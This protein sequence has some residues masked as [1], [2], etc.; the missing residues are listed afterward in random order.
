MNT[1]VILSYQ[2]D[3]ILAAIADDVLFRLRKNISLSD[4]SSP[5]QHYENKTTKIV[6]DAI[7]FKLAC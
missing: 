1:F 4:L 2:G 7:G 6:V 3:A 5:Q